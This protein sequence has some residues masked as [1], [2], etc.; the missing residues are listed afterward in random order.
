MANFTTLAPAPRISFDFG[1]LGATNY[2]M[3]Y[4]GLTSISVYITLSST[5]KDVSHLR[6]D[7]DPTETYNHTASRRSIALFAIEYASLLGIR[8]RATGPGGTITLNY[9]DPGGEEATKN[10]Y[11]S[12]GWNL[13]SAST[14]DDRYINM[15]RTYGPGS[16]T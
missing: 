13:R 16:Y 14:G 3:E 10:F 12:R 6:T 11:R 9:G 7:L 5:N 2:R 4:T 15:S 1:G 8:I